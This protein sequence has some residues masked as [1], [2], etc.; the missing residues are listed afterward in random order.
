MKLK[1]VLFDLGN[2]LAEYYTRAEFPGVLKLA[3][4]EV[5]IYLDSHGLVIPRP[6]ELWI[7]IEAENHEARNYRV[8][9][10][11]ARLRRI[12]GVS[13]DSH[14]EAMCRAFLKPTFALGR[15]YED[16]V[17]VLQELRSMGIRT[18]IVSNSPCGS[19]AR[20]WRE[21]IERLGLRE[22]VDA[23][24]FCGDV[25]WRKPARPI[26]LH[27][28]SKLGLAAEDC[29]FVGDHPRWDLAGPKAVGIEAVLIDRRGVV[30]DTGEDPISDLYE[31][32]AR[33]KLSTCSS[34]HRPDFQAV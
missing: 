34:V 22:Y 2:T 20:L 28:L 14:I 21:E 24:V 26:F 16:S 29:V 31:F 25:G 8:K 10:L 13:D 5:E 12:F 1:G 33:L 6:D 32:L 15:C 3:I 23:V 7:R 18:A 11:E 9:P 30:Q 27:T 19:P 4:S 17:P